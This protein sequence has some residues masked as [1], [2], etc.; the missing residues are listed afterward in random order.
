MFLLKFGKIIRLNIFFV[1]NEKK[2][3]K[4]CE[5]IKIGV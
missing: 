3:A 2:G 1:N 4:H 5:I